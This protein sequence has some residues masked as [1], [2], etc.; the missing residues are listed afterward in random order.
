MLNTQV[1]VI[2]TLDNY[3]GF[4]RIGASDTYNGPSSQLVRIAG[5]VLT[6]GEIIPWPS[7]C[8]VNC[9]YNVSFTGPAWDCLEIDPRTYSVPNLTTTLDP[10]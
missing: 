4:F 2:S 9:T 3:V 6:T 10:Y 5:R 7:P 8:G 1:P